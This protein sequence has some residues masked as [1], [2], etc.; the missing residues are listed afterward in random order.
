MA[1][2]SFAPGLPSS[3]KVLALVH[4]KAYINRMKKVS[5]APCL[6]PKALAAVAAVEGLH[7]SA[8]SR[9]RLAKYEAAGLSMDERRRA[10]LQTY[11]GAR[12]S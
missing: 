10:I 7:L 9:K 11:K 6:T 8:D 3:A 2:R 12:C 4:F 1:T 5:S